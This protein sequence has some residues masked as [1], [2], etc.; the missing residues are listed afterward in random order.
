MSG[1]DRSRYQHPPA[2]GRL[3]PA[4]AKKR[5]RQKKMAFTFYY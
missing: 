3:V 2:G 1:P 5:K 4:D